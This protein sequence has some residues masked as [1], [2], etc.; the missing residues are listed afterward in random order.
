[1][2]KIRKI[3]RGWY[4]ING[5]QMFFRSKWE[6]NYAL[7]LDWLKKIG[8]IKDWKYEEDVFIFEKIKFGTRSYRPDFKIFNNDGSIHYDE[9]KGYMNSQSKTKINRMR[10]YYPKIK[11]N[12]ID[13]K[14]YNSIKNKVG[15]MLKFY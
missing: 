11:L 5:I 1:M 6:V 15:G 14:A 9:V 2:D 10:I 3:K 8:E 7:Y 4:D 12:I 13:E